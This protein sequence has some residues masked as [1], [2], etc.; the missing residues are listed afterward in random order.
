MDVSRTGR[1][2]GT[3][4]LLCQPRRSAVRRRA[5]CG[6]LDGA[7]RRGSAASPHGQPNVL[8]AQQRGTQRRAWWRGRTAQRRLC[9]SA[10]PFVAPHR[11]AAW[12]VSLTGREPVGLSAWPGDEAGQP[13]VVLCGSAAWPRGALRPISAG[14]CRAAPH[15]PLRG[16]A[17]QPDTD[18]EWTCSAVDVPRHS[19]VP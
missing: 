9:G 13:G 4:A 7:V 3:G 14:A 10:V 2:P 6:W 15:T 12:T 17:G 1:Q 5:M 18:S 8:W 19:Q 11:L 16:G